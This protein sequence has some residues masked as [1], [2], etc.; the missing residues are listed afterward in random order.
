LSMQDAKPA[1][2]P[3]KAPPIEELL[4]LTEDSNEIVATAQLT[5]KESDT[6]QPT[7]KQ[8]PTV[9]AEESMEEK[10]SAV[11]EKRRLFAEAA[12]RRLVVE[13]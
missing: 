9:T 8:E 7:E 4:D 10:S 3:T 6:I 1:A 13:K 11:K 2:I 5:E 12:M